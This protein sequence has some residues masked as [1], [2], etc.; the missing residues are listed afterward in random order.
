MTPKQLVSL[1]DKL[2]WTQQQMAEYLGLRN[3][4]QVW[5]MEHGVTR[6]EGPE[7]HPCCSSFRRANQPGAQ[8]GDHVQEVKNYFPEKSTFF[9]NFPIAS[10]RLPC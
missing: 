5:H 1:R 8:Q 7:A 3:R 10:L 6:I 4:V 2:G 9:F